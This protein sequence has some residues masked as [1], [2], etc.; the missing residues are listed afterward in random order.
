M[1]LR[2]THRNLNLVQKSVKTSPEANIYGE[3]NSVVIDF[4]FKRFLKVKI[5]NIRKKVEIAQLKNHK[6]EKS[7][8]R[9][10]NK[11]D[12]ELGTEKTRKCNA[13]KTEITKIREDM[14]FKQNNRN[15]NG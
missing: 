10:E 8:H 4:S 9:E 12:R 15:K 6:R 11:N 1:K 2:T 14:R 7:Q 5:E 13:L 3:H